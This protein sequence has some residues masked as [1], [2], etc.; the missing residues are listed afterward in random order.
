MDKPLWDQL[1][2]E[3]K[4]YQKVNNLGGTPMMTWIFL[5][6][7]VALFIFLVVMIVKENSP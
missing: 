5:G 1:H 2:K 6:L 4:L 7:G 3:R